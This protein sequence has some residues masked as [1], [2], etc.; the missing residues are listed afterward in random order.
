MDKMPRDL[1][2]KLKIAEEQSESKTNRI[3][4]EEMMTRLDNLTVERIQ[5]LAAR[6]FV[7]SRPTV[8]AIGPVEQ[9]L[10]TDAI[11]ERLKSGGSF[12]PLRAAG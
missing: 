6:I 10:E 8:S 1:Y 4:H 12:V 2:Q 3:S 5:D 11:G 7:T 9:L